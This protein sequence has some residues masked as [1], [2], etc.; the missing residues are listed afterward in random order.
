MLCIHKGDGGREKKV[1]VLAIN[2]MSRVK[3]DVVSVV[4]DEQVD[5]ERCGQPM[6]FYT[7]LKRMTLPT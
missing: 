5:D 3:R 1:A 6:G 4:K 7:W 2:A